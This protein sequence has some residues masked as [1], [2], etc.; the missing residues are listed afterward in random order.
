MPSVP[1]EITAPVK[2]DSRKISLILSQRG[3]EDSKIDT[4]EDNFILQF[5]FPF[6]NPFYKQRYVSFKVLFMYIKLFRC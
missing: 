5:E 2:L 3:M 4:Y 6:E 1:N